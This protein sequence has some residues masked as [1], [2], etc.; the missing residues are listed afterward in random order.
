M[1]LKDR[2]EKTDLHLF[3]RPER[4][5]TLELDDAPPAAPE[6]FGGDGDGVA[7]GSRVALVL[8]LE[9]PEVVVG[10]RLSA[11]LVPKSWKSR[12]TIELLDSLARAAEVLIYLPVRGGARE[13]LEK[14]C[15]LFSDG[16]LKSS[17]DEYLLEPLYSG[18]GGVPV[19][20]AGEPDKM[21]PCMRAFDAKLAELKEKMAAAKRDREAAGLPSRTF[22]TLND[23]DSTNERLSRVEMQIQQLGRRVD[24]IQQSLDGT[25]TEKE[26][27]LEQ[28]IEERLEQRLARRFEEEWVEVNKKRRLV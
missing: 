6:R 23:V 5:R 13:V 8:T 3:L 17:R 27:Q 21:L 14:A 28:Q 11:P 26:R 20:G 15:G 1:S 10:P 22:A 19:G 4:F 25:A 24:E 18:E 2:R 9:P 12:E 16:G 7:S